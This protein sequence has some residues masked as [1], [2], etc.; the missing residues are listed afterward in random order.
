MQAQIKFF[1]ITIILFLNSFSAFAHITVQGYTN[2]ESLNE[3]PY[4]TFICHN[5]FIGMSNEKGYFNFQIHDSLKFD[6]IQ[7]KHLGF[8]TN[9]EQIIVLNRTSNIL[10]DFVV[11]FRII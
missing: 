5:K 6:S 1:A 3:L 11:K 10:N 2:D 8:S 7:Y 9:N 4:V